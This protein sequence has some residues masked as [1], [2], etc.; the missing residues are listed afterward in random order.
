MNHPEQDDSEVTDTGAAKSHRSGELRDRESDA[1]VLVAETAGELTAEVIQGRLE[2]A[3]IPSALQY[4]SMGTSLFPVP[5]VPLGLVR[6][7]VPRDFADEAVALLS[8]EFDLDEP[9]SEEED[10]IADAADA[11]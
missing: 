3:G 4:E 11:G 10:V 9:F 1:L 8:T 6:V 5:S 2:S 7:L